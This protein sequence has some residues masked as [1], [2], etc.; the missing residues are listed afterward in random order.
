MKTSRFGYAVLT[1]LG[2][3]VGSS[4]ASPAVIQKTPD[5]VLIGWNSLGMHCINP[6]Y[7]KLVILPPANTLMVQVIKRGDPPVIVTK[8]LDLSYKVE[9]NDSSVDHCNF[10]D[11]ADQLF[12][13]TL[14]P[15]VGLTGNRLKGALV[16]NG[17]HFEATAIPV[18]PYNNNGTWNPYQ[19]AQ[20]TLKDKRGTVQTTRVVLPVSDEL[21]CD[22]CHADGGDGTMN[23][24]STPSIEENILRA[25]DYLH[26]ELK[27]A[28][29]QPV[30]CASCHADPALGAPGKAGT[31]NLSLAMHG[32]HKQFSD[33]TCYSCHPGPQTHCLRTAIANMGHV[34][35]DPNCQRCH[36]TMDQL[37]AGLE[38]GRQPWAEEPTCAQCHGQVFDTK[39]VLYR[40]SAGHGGVRCTTCHNSPHAWWPSQ[41]AV[42]NI[43]PIRLQGSPRAV[44][45]CAI[46]HTKPQPGTSP[47]PPHG[48]GVP[49]AL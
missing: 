47:H 5:Y 21:H 10:W 32:W 25:H 33:A 22:Q 46:C 1:I 19:V 12:G 7:D 29:S 16:V 3:T 27:L 13:V 31:K 28:E 8:G 39:G 43:Q 18:L 34:D 45:D 36:G 40:E 2:L 30:L 6:T 35:E 37:A 24:V 17:D 42:D 44:R 38:S 11:F 26:P 15:G 9:N 23:I 20:V 14:S 48:P 41:L 49:A 4:L